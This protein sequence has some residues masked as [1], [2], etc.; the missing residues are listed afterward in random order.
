MMRSSA[1]KLSIIKNDKP[2]PAC[3]IRKEELS[4]MPRTR[5]LGAGSF[6]AVYLGSY[7][8]QTVAI[9]TIQINPTEA[10]KIDAFK[11]EITIM[12]TLTQSQQ[13]DQKT[14]STFANFYGYVINNTHYSLVMEYMPNGNLQN[15]IT[16]Y[17]Q[18]SN[19]YCYSIIKS[20]VAGVEL[21][22][23]N[24]IIHCDIKPDNVLLRFTDQ[25]VQ[26]FLCDF[27]L[28]NFDDTRI[29][30]R[31]KGAPLY[32]APEMVLRYAN[33]SKKTDIYSM[34]LVMWEVSAW[35]IIY[36][37]IMT[38]EDLAALHTAKKREPIPAHC[39]I[40][41]LIT[42]GWAHR[43]QKRPEANEMATL[44]ARE[45]TQE[46]AKSKGENDTVS[47]NVGE[48]RSNPL[49]QS[50]DNS[51]AS[52]VADSNEVRKSLKSSCRTQ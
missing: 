33:N 15:Y 46:P 5:K 38:H 16:H 19:S 22:H 13:A 43:P 52:S 24:N 51:N 42:L 17:S 37:N 44:L 31:G 35:K 1:P 10:A 7:H 21:M 27:G 6:G 23:R 8:G 39:K 11:N 18:P 48:T 36:A 40:A 41:H 30:I 14:S 47:N 28:S 12:H 34:S 25:A 29:K 50:V 45:F 9:K 20:I 3:Q 2:F 26:A 4:F 32:Q 49:L